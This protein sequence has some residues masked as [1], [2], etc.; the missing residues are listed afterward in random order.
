MPTIPSYPSQTVPNNSD[1]LVIQDGVAAITKNITRS[2]FLSGAPLPNNTVTTAAI[3]SAAITAT[4][5]DFTTFPTEFPNFSVSLGTS[6]TS[7]NGAVVKLD[8][9]QYDTAS[10]FNTTTWLYTVSKAGKYHFSWNINSATATKILSGLNKN[11]VTV[12]RGSW[13]ADTGG[14]VGSSGS[15]DLLLAVGDTIELQC[16][17]G[18]GTV[19]LDSGI[20]QTYLTGHMFSK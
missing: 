20:A 9:V 4:K 16:V 8:T 1:Q 13:V 14:F 12:A 15:K 7:A 18:A 6:Q 5:I 11:A 10:G 19:T 3:A 17:Q 2:A